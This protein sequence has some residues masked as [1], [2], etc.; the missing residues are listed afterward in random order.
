VSGNRLAVRVFL[1]FFSLFLFSLFSAVAQANDAKFGW[2]PNTETNLAGYKIYYGTA[3]GSYTSAVDVGNPPAIDGQVTATLSGFTAGVTYYFAATAYDTDGFESDYSTEVVWTVPVE[4]V[5]PPTASDTVLSIAEDTAGSGQLAGLSQDG[6]ALTYQLVTSGLLGSAVILDAASPAFRYTPSANVHGVDSFTYKVSDVHGESNIATVTVIIQPVNDI[7]AADPAQL[8]TDEDLPVS[9]KLGGH[10][11]DGDNLRY[12]LVSNGSLGQV[13]LTDASTGAFKYTPA[14]QLSGTDSFTFKV[15]DGAADSNIAT[16]SVSIR[17][18]NDAPVA[19]MAQLSTDEDLPVSSKLGGQDLDGDNLSYSLVSNG[20]LGQVVLTDASTGAFRYTPAAQLSGTDSFTFKVN[21]G[22]A[23]SNIATVSI[24]IRPVNDAPVAAMAQLSTDEDLPVS[25]KLG[26]QDLDGDNLSYSLVSNGSLGQVVLTDASTGAFRYT[27][28][29]EQSGADSFTFKVNDGAADSNI[30]TVSISIKAVNDAPVAADGVLS[31]NENAAASGVLVGTDPDSSAL[32]YSIISNASLGTV[33][34]LDPTTGAYQYTPLAGEFGEDVFQ[35]AVTDDQGAV[36]N[37]ATITVS[38]A[39]A[40]ADF[41][42]EMGELTV[43]S[44]W[45]VVTFT[46]PFV[47]PV[48]VAKPASNNDADPCVV[49]IR[50]LTPTGFEIR[51]QNWNY[52]PDSHASEQ[53]SF[54]ALERGTHMLED[55][56]MIE[57]G[58]F[59]T[60]KVGAFV[61]VKWTK[62]FTVVP[63][64]AASIVST[65]D[66]DAVDGRMRKISTTGFEY[67]MREQEIN[68]KVHGLESIAYIAWEPSAGQAGN[69]VYEIGVT[70]DAVTDKWHVLPFSEPFPAAPRLIADMQTTGGADTSNLRYSELTADSVQVK[71]AEEQSKDLET[72]HT[73][74]IVGFMAFSRAEGDTDPDLD[75]VTTQDELEIY[76]TSPSEADSDHDGLDDGEELNYWRDDWDADVDQDGL[77]NLLDPDADNDG[78]SD[79]VEYL[80]LT[81][82]AMPSAHPDFPAVAADE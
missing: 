80:N 59:A 23:D 53:V 27:P 57:A 19:V 50:N 3:S 6:S 4:V 65:N 78:Y 66:T 34:I 26:G 37:S 68:S 21:D 31:V 11:L 69:L 73:T 32:T 9:G 55:G 61:P 49:R 56:T 1:R 38:I 70:A 41:P 82:P 28:A 13:V 72:S 60:N 12:S 22:A 24:S 62:T 44:N 40:T 20:S 47:A 52:L 14:A 81:D 5:S 29:A 30:A 43:N 67:T 36:S 64:V 48:V 15:N 39:Q 76:G 45:S 2:S 25:G 71:V 42:L 8:S 46:K 35:F 54:I 17:P 10:D 75:G 63:V 77:V 33:T 18:V 7:P 16:V 74:E 58:M 79:G 51:L